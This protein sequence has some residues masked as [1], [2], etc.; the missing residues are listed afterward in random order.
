MQTA[1][2]RVETRGVGLRQFLWAGPIAGLAVGVVARAWM[3]WIT[4]DPEFSWT[5]TIGIVVVFVVF[6][7]AQAG[8]RV[9][10]VRVRSPRRVTGVRAVAGVLSLGLF[11]AAGAVMFPTV[12]FGSLALWR[13][14]FHRLVRSLLVIAALPAPIYVTSTIASDHGWSPATIGRIMVFVAIY[15]AVIVATRPTVEAVKAWWVAS[16]RAVATLVV[17]LGS[18]VGIALYVGGI[19]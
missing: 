5:G 2:A 19:A 1:A 18:F 4:V 14:G 12:L 3:R 15:A 6:F 9:A 8:A 13:S 16:R 7:S 10:R 17:L 11:G